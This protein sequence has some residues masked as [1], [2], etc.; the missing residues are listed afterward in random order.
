MGFIRTPLSILLSMEREGT[1]SNCY[2]LLYRGKLLEDD[3]TLASLDI[4]PQSIL[5]LV[6]HPRDVILISVKMPNG[7][8]VKSEVKALFTIH[9]VKL[10]IGSMV[11]FS[12]AGHNLL[13]AGKKLADSK[14]LACY[15]IGENHVLEISTP[16]F[17][18]FVKD[19]HG[20]TIILDVREDETIWCLKHK[21]FD[22]LHVPVEVQS[23]KFARK[24]LKDDLDLASY[25][26][27]KDSTLHLVFRSSTVHWINFQK[28]DLKF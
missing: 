16:T 22:K 4:P 12:V 21:V 19:W 23:L 28:S 7:E 25:N 24:L 15:D 6:F 10:I 9:D 26:I 3:R 17:Q 27:Q 8:I 5:Y 20:K 2:S 11:G 14:T 13:H 18:I 1:Q